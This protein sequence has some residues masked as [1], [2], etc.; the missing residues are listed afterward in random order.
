MEQLCSKSSPVYLNTN[1]VPFSNVNV[2]RF[3]NLEKAPCLSYIIMKI[4]RGKSGIMNENWLIIVLRG[5]M[6]KRIV[7]KLQEGPLGT[8]NVVV[9]GQA[10]QAV[11]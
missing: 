10:A 11:V 7:Q 8:Y 9:L 6:F 3:F 2:T 4:N 5:G 1:P